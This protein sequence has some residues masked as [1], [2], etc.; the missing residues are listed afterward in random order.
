M[1]DFKDANPLPADIL[2]NGRG[3]V[4][5]AVAVDGDRLGAATLDGGTVR[6]VEVMPDAA[7]GDCLLIDGHAWTHPLSA[8]AYSWVRAAPE[9]VLVA[10]MRGAVVVD[11]VRA[12]IVGS[13]PGRI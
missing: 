4:I 9:T 7:S 5:V 1:E 10:E 3:D 12:R 13:E 6:S 8:D 2:R 11:V